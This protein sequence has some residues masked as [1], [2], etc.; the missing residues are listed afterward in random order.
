VCCRSFLNLGHVPYLHV[1]RPKKTHI[2]FEIRLGW[3]ISCSH[4][5]HIKY[6]KTRKDLTDCNYNW[7]MEHPWI[8]MYFTVTWTAWRQYSLNLIYHAYS[9]VTYI[10]VVLFQKNP[11]T[12]INVLSNSQVQTFENLKGHT[13]L[14]ISWIKQSKFYPYGPWKMFYNEKKQVIQVHKIIVSSFKFVKKICI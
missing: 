1:P 13:F 7:Y 2:I 14:K 4:F 9:H 10:K 8:H 5:D 11:K 3:N 12:H 6:N